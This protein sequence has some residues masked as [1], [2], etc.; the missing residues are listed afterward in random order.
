[1][2]RVLDEE[3]GKKGGAIGETFGKMN[4]VAESVKRA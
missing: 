2:G 4:E 1:M 3:D